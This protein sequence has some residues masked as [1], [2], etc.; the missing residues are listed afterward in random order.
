MMFSGKKATAKLFIGDIAV[1][2]FSLW[3]TLLIRY[4]EFPTMLMLVDHLQ[5]FSGLFI[6]WIVVFYLF[7]LYSK[8]AALFKSELPATIVRVQLFNVALAAL[9]FF[10]APN[11]GIAPKTNLL[12]YL[13]V[14]VLAVFLWRLWAVPRI[15]QPSVR[16]RIAVIG[17]GSEVNELVEE[18]N[19]NPRYPLACDLVVMP[20]DAVE[21]FDAVMQMLQH[22]NISIL[23]VDR[24][25]QSLVK[26]L[27]RIYDLTFIK[28]TCMFVDFHSL[29]EE[30]FDR[31]PLSLLNY[32]WFLEYLSVPV[33]ILYVLAKRVI[34]IVGG[35]LV[36]II[37]LI[38]T[39]L[40]YVAMKIEDG[41]P[42]FIE[43]DRF[44]QYGT[45]IKIYK[46][47]S[48]RFNNKSSDAWIKEDN[49][50]NMNSVTCVG[51]ILR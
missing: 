3:L 11:L 19:S 28:R 36:G 23:A 34:D 4:G 17:E 31:V 50:N 21:D 32:S 18:I 43:Q 38:I 14:S 39:P 6:L 29:Y 49:K 8:N 9:L 13:A 10:L 15:M 47:R 48:M 24:G 42:L 37:T 7:G 2:I 33:P 1:F 20:K 41:G 27:D 30:V 12:I 40:I 51:N 35:L 26:I 25:N 44:G 22:R 5:I 16:E 46:F 45:T